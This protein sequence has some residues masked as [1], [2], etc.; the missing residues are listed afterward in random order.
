MTAAQLAT[1]YETLQQHCK[2]ELTKSKPRDRV[3]LPLIKALL[4][5]DGCLSKMML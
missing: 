3:L 4:L 5:Q 2:E 1:D